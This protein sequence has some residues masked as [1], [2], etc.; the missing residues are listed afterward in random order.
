MGSTKLGAKMKIGNL[1]IGLLAGRGPVTDKYLAATLRSLCDIAKQGD[2]AA[3]DEMIVQVGR[4]APPANETAA[5]RRGLILLALAMG[6]PPE[7]VEQQLRSM[8][9]AGHTLPVFKQDAN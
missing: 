8:V 6:P 9:S 3:M 7:D 5:I 2:A 4:C 1:L